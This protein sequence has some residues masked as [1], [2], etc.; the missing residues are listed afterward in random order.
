MIKKYF[1]MTII[2]ASIS[3]A[4]CSDDDD[5]ETPIT[6]TPNPGGEMEEEENPG[7]G[8]NPMPTPGTATPGVGGTAFDT[9]ANSPDHTSLAAAVTAAGLAD[10][11]DAGEFT[12]FAPDNDAFAA[13]GDDAPTGDDLARILTY[14]VVAGTQTSTVLSTALGEANEDMPATLDTILV[15]GS[16]DAAVTQSLEFGLSD[17]A[18]SGVS[19]NDVAIDAVDLVLR[20]DDEDDSVAA[21]GIVHSI[22]TILIPPA[23]PVVDPGVGPTNPPVG[24]E[25]TGVQADLEAAGNYAGFI[26]LSSSIG[27]QSYDTNA[28]TVFAP[29]DEAIDDDD[30]T[31]DL[32]IQDHIA[33]SGAFT[34]AAL[35]AAGS[36]TTNAQKS[37]TVTGT[38][39]ALLVDGKAVSVV[40]TGAGGAQIYTIDGTLR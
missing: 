31:G 25:S 37:Y 15:D 27:V 4:A 40:A 24:G 20:G 38:E 1:A 3:L 10:T 28:W 22:G 34:P 14:H 19:V 35:L 5:D 2:A 36:V 18:P 9:I 21:S 12:V 6:P 23:A 32:D 13:L 26:N 17:T 39:A 11:L 7:S 29:T 8:E 30:G 16:G 33:T